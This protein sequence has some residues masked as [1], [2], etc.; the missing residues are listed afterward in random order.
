MKQIRQ[1]LHLFLSN[2]KF[3]WN[4]IFGF[5][6]YEMT[7]FRALDTLAIYSNIFKIKLL[8][9]ITLGKDARI[10]MHPPKNNRFSTDEI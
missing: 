10:Q 8:M 7:N 2:D 1:Q 5:W 3:Q 6:I 9:Q 4:D